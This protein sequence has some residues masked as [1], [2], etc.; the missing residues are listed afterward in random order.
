LRNF[1][2]W[3]RLA[4]GRVEEIA[5]ISRSIADRIQ[6][7]YQRQARVIYPPVE[8]GRFRPSGVRGDFYV[9]VSRLVAHKRIDLIVEAFSRLDLPLMIV[10]EGPELKRLQ[11]ASAPNIQFLGRQ[12]DEKVADL[13][14]QTRGFVCAAE[15]DFRHRH[16]RGAGGG[17]SRHCLRDGRRTGN[18]AGWEAQ[19][20]FSPNRQPKV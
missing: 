2:K 17:L 8:M 14:G 4:V 6:S 16:R 18:R 5:A 19:V 15:E 11:A 12:P 1:R 9:T 20:C 3:D 10:G 13:L 7:A